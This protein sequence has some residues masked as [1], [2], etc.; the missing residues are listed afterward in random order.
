MVAMH[1]M[2]P[3][4]RDPN[5]RMPT[6]SEFL[7]GGERRGAPGTPP[8]IHPPPHRASPPYHLP[9]NNLRVS[10]VQGETRWHDPA[11]NRDIANWARTISGS[12]RDQDVLLLATDALSAW[13]LRRE[14]EGRPVW[15][16]VTAG[17]RGQAWFEGLVEKAREDGVR[18]DDM[19]VVRITFN[20]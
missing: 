13:L 15:R 6:I 7:C 8:T 14:E 2:L 17:L 10:L 18:N 12:L 5:A 3:G 9:M 20:G 11:G 4:L 1:P 16:W 19:T